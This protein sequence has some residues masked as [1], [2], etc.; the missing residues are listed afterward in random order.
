[1]GQCQI[2]QCYR[3]WS[4]CKKKVFILKIIY[5]KLQEVFNHMNFLAEK[6]LSQAQN[7]RI[8]TLA[9]NKAKKER[10]KQ[11]IKQQLKL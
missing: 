11:T 9:S 8:R 6:W 10:Q 1:M 2:L 5:F 3:K 4:F 7:G